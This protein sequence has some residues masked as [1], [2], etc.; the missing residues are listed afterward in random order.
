MYPNTD[1]TSAVAAN[2]ANLE[3]DKITGKGLSTEDYTTA[4]KTKLASLSTTSNGADL[5]DY[6]KLQIYLL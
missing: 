6:A 5:T 3:V 1:F 4:E 2:T